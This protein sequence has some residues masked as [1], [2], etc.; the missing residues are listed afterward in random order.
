M[1]AEQNIPGT[2][3]VPIHEGVMLSQKSSWRVR[4]SRPPRRAPDEAACRG[5]RGF[6]ART[7]RPAAL[8]EVPP[9]AASAAELGTSGLDQLDRAYNSTPSPLY[10]RA[11]AHL[12]RGLTP[13]PR[14]GGEHG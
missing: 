9:A 11:R 13:P 5:E 8:G 4:A 10:A 12:E 2:G 14:A 7:V 6:R 1:V 3:A